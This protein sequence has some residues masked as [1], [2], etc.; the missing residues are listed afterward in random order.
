VGF[1]E[2]ALDTGSA[3]FQI[4]GRASDQ[5]LIH[6]HNRKIAMNARKK[7]VQGPLDRVSEHEPPDRIARLEHQVAELQKDVAMLKRVSGWPLLAD[8]GNEFEGKKKPGPKEKISDEDLLQY[9]DAIVLWLEPFWSW[10]N[11]HLFQGNTCEQVGAILEAVAAEPDFR[12]EWQTR[13]LQ[14]TA[15]LCEFLW[16]E[17]FRKT[18]PKAAVA[19]ALTLPL[20]DVRRRRAANQFPSRQIANAMAGVPDIGWRRSLDRC[21]AQPSAAFVA[22]SMDM[23]YCDTC[24]IPTPKD[25]DLTGASC[26]VPKPL[27]PILARSS[28]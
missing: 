6:G 24:G 18:L 11:E 10:L 26:P 12:P 7:K 20:E 3:D 9:R 4:A 23:F 1:S 17:R 14:N 2:R 21:S 13:L 27:Q 15:A 28:K 8:E 19:D 16:G 5:K 22:V 25:R